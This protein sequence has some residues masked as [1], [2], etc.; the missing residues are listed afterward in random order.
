MAFLNDFQWTFNDFRGLPSLS[1]TF[2]APETE[3]PREKH[4]DEAREV[5]RVRGAA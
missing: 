5:P 3:R 4:G 1:A 2:S